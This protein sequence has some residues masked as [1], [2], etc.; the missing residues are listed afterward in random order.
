[1]SP[2]SI[3][4][5]AVTLAVGAGARWLI[6]DWKLFTLAVVPICGAV[7]A[8]I[9]VIRHQAVGLSAA[10]LVICLGFFLLVRLIPTV[11]H[12]AVSLLEMLGH[13]F[14]KFGRGVRKLLRR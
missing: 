1:M 6:R 3:I 13:A 12:E 7:L 11:D 4:R 9:R 8:G 5:S 2:G 14:A 10:A